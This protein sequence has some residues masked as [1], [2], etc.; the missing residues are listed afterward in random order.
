MKSTRLATAFAMVCTVFTTAAQAQVIEAPSI[1]TPSS[2]KPIG[3]TYDYYEIGQPDVE[4][5][6]SDVPEIVD[7]AHDVVVDAPPCDGDACDGDGCDGCGD[8]C[9]TCYLFGPEEPW[10]LQEYLFGDCECAPTIGGWMEYGYHSNNVPLSFNRFDLFSFSDVDQGQLNQSWLYIEKE[11]NGDCGWGW[12]YRADIMYGTDSHKT[13]AFGNSTSA[14][15]FTNGWDNS[16]DNGIYG[17][18]MPQAYVEVAKGDLSIKGGHFYTLVGYEV[19]TAPDNFFYTHALTMFNSEPFT[20]TGVLATYGYSDDIEIYAGWT[21]GWDTGFDT[22]DGGSSWLG[23][24]SLTLSEHLS[25]T[26]ISTAG[27]FGL[28]GRNAYS[29]SIVMNAQL[30]DKLEYVIQSDMVSIG[31]VNPNGIA[32]GGLPGGNVNVPLGNDQVGINQYMFYTIN[33][34]LSVGGRMEWWKTDG[35][36]F[37]ELTGGINY[38]PH[39]NVIIRPEVR[40]DW[41]PARL[42][43]SRNSGIF[44]YPV[45]VNDV[46]T[47][48]ISGIFTF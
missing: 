5:S 13:Q 24:A 6:P 43:A 33:D 10:T 2:V 4:T 11:A 46:T 23:G 16:W 32:P 39:A 38:K 36:S 3:F 21:A 42:P 8:G 18:A 29:H 44:P 48:S 12:G 7:D 27:N 1:E 35:V 47:F 14:A 45:G 22:L 25:V 9:C 19:V 17:W 30:T 37:H 26:Y 28:R 31:Q 15:G 40:Y 34:C 20:H 41:T